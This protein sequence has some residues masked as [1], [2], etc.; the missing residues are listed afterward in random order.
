MI[1]CS[2]A[3]FGVH[4]WARACR[5]SFA[6]L[7]TAWLVGA[8]GRWAF[9]KQAGF[10]STLALRQRRGLFCFTRV[11][12]LGCAVL[13]GNHCARERGAWR[14]PLDDEEPAAST[15]DLHRLGPIGAGL[16]LKGLDRH[17]LPVRRGGLVFAALRTIVRGRRGPGGG[18]GRSAAWR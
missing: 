16:L 7:L 3:V 2:Y 18:C 5:L 15:V 6:C 9:G 1:A 10:Y 17:R 12:N 11:L 4:D 13:T 8:M 14:V